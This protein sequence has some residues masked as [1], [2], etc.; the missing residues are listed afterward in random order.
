M[1]RPSRAAGA[2]GDEGKKKRTMKKKD[3]NAPKRGKSAYMFW[4][5]ENR[6]RLTKPGM[7]VTEVTKLAGA[8]WREVTEKSKWEAMAKDDKDRYER[9]MAAYRETQK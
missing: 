7:P 8:E 9:E 6:A 4:L 3:P 2:A 1:A 5:A